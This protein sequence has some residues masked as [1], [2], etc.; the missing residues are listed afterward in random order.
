MKH[1][2]FTLVLEA[3][4]DERDPDQR[5]KR[6]LKFALRGLR[7]KCRSIVLVKDEPDG[8]P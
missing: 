7:L 2:R 3:L 8:A 6:L 4:P 5:L 1:P